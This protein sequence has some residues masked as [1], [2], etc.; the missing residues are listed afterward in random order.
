MVTHWNT[1]ELVAQERVR[2]SFIGSP[3]TGTYIN[4]DFIPLD[5]THVKE[6]PVVLWAPSSPRYWKFSIG[7]SILTTFLGAVVVATLSL[8]VFR[9]FVQ[10]AIQQT[11]GSI[12]AGI[13]NAV[14]IIIFNT[15]YRK[16]AS[17]LTEWEN[18]RTESEYE[19]SFIVKNFLFQ[20]VNSYVSLFYVAF[21]KGKYAIFGLTDFVDT[22][23]PDCMSELSVQLGTIF[24][25]QIFIGQTNEV[26]I[27]WLK[28]KV[29]LWTETRALRAKHQDLQATQPEIEAKLGDYADA[30]DDYNE[31]AIQFGYI[32]L[33]AAAFPLAPLAA[34][35]NNIVE[36]RTDAFKLLGTMK[37]PHPR[38]AKNIGNW[39]DILEIISY[40]AVITN[41]S[42]IFFTSK[43]VHLIL[44]ENTDFWVRVMVAVIVEH[45]VF[46]LK[47][48][49]ARIIPDTPKWVRRAAALR[50]YLKENAEQQYLEE[51]MEKTNVDNAD[52]QR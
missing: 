32:T 19:N 43:Q 17:K 24:L 1:N 42:L 35:I 21:V 6:P 41:V 8:M 39:Y 13:V 30:F 15:I 29:G 10:R 47:W 52:E 27:P 46:M 2:P 3:R 18:Y 7:L 50:E 5:T 49:V 20:F 34:L 16:V 33:F 36:M 37:R 14:I 4:G 22:C 38:T 11:F 9:L 26:L 31:M 48:I 51:E 28:G 12:I 23:K 25:T 45:L 44:D 40:L